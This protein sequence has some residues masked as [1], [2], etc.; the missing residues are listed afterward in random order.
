MGAERKNSISKNVFHLFYSTAFSSGLNALSLVIL[1]SYL[2]SQSYGMFSVA[3]AFAL[4]MGYFTDTGIS[5][6]ALR[7][8]AKRGVS[9]P[10]VISSYIKIRLALLGITLIGGFFLIQLL[11]QGSTELIRMMY[12]L[13]F[14]MVTGLA[15]QGISVTYFQLTEEMQYLG[16][17]RISSASLLI[18]FICLGMTF[19]MEP[20]VICFL[21]GSSYLLAGIGGLCLT[22]MRVTIR[23]RSAFHKGLLKN[24][25]P[26]IISG[27]LIVILPQLGP[28]LLE[29]TLTLKQVGLFAVAYRIPS[30]LYQIPGVLAGA[31]YPAL[32]KSYNGKGATEHLQLNLTQLKIMALLGVTMMVPLYYMPEI[33][34]SV[35]FGDKW[36][37]ASIGLRILSFLLLLQSI[38]I[39]LADGMTTRNLQSRRTI[40]QAMAVVGGIG[41]YTF[42]SQKYGVTGAAFAGAAIELLSLAGFWLL[43][44]ARVTIAK[45]ALLPY[46]SFFALIFVVITY[47]FSKWPFLAAILHLLCL[48]FFAASDRE[49]SHKLIS[50]M[51]KKLHFKKRG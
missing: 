45:K 48:L 32:F 28:I 44:P 18:I 5:V 19:S 41:L 43:N 10:A 37:S 40:V 42:F 26:F 36:L 46:L 34:I 25:V 20:N 39:A 17:I 49:L 33:I 31:F 51:L 23:F 4:I 11:Y 8:G 13:I 30:A 47:F 6:A 24:I 9:V 12:C 2:G 29:K 14:P 27:L 50:I 22:A 1:A 3:L 15:M 21:Y 35:L 7:E 38:N 16:F